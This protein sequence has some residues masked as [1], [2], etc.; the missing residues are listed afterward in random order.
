[1][2]INFISN[3]TLLR[4]SL[5]C[6]LEGLSKDIIVRNFEKCS[7]V[8]TSKSH[9]FRPEVI[10]VHSSM[11]D[12]GIECIHGLK[13]ILHTLPIAILSDSN[14][15]KITR[16]ELIECRV[17]IIPMTYSGELILSVIEFI[18]KGGLFFSSSSA[19]CCLAKNNKNDTAITF[20]ILTSREREVLIELCRGLSNKE[21][22]RA[23]SIGDVTVRLHLRGI[24]RKLGVRNRTQ[25]ALMAIDY[26]FSALSSQQNGGVEKNNKRP[27]GLCAAPSSA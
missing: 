15:L 9:D 21:I 14:G 24:F 20:E 10:I 19:D 5:K 17:S 12:G 7:D 8:E 26:N 11:F 3:N 16:D 1:M 2:H 22:A 25:A 27:A 13:K 23:L 18:A 6:Y 4:E